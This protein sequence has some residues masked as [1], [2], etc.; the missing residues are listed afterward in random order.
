MKRLF[1]VFFLLMVV[2]FSYSHG[3]RSGS[4]NDEQAFSINWGQNISTFSYKANGISDPNMNWAFHSAYAFNYDHKFKS[5]LFYRPEIGYKHF[6]AISSIYNQ[7]INWSLSYVDINFGGG[8]MIGKEDN[9]IKPYFGLSYY[10][11]YLLNAQQ[12]FGSYYYDIL[13]EKAIKKTD[14]GFIGYLGVNYQIDPTHHLFTAFI[15]A[16]VSYG[17]RQLEL[18]NNVNEDYNK[19]ELHNLAISPYIGIRYI[20]IN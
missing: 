4:R 6:G 19:Q 9:N 18:N 11:S 20:I 8:F 16:R 13:K 7:R 2:N 14:Y 1:I 3:F 15:E 10:F 5:G 17:A 12:T